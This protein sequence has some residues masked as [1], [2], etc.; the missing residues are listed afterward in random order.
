MSVLGS[1]MQNQRH[2]QMLHACVTY[3][4]PAVVPT[5]WANLAWLSGYFTVGSM[6][7]QA[8]TGLSLCHEMILHSIYILHSCV[9][10]ASQLEGCSTNQTVIAAQQG[11]HSLS[12]CMLQMIW[13]AR[14]ALSGMLTAAQLSNASTRK[15]LAMRDRLASCKT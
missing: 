6:L 12:K 2:Y 14:R 10:D 9:L 11:L 1:A 8:T 15:P 7:E 5:K 13:H 4:F 3:T